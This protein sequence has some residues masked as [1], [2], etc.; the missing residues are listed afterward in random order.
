MIKP[1]PI[2]AILQCGAGHELDEIELALRRRLD[3]LHRVESVSQVL[4]CMDAQAGRVC[5]VF[6]DATVVVDYTH[7]RSLCATGTSPALV[8]IM[9]DP[10]VD[11]VVDAIRFGIVDVLESTASAERC[12]LAIDRA[13]R[14]IEPTLSSEAEG[15]SLRDALA[16]PERRII[17]AALERNAWN[18]LRTARQLRIDRTTLYKKMKQLGIAA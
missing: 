12:R 6:V 7:L 16:A 17:M 1:P 14:S 18:R 10:A 8:L 2:T 4:A 13:S 11:E 9:D 3:S 5:I 15:G